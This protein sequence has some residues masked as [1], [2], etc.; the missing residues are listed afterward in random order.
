MS[1]KIIEWSRHEAVAVLDD[2]GV[3]GQRLGP[4]S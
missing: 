2:I 3:D 1:R 4:V